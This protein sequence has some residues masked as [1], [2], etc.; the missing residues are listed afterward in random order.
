MKENVTAAL[1]MMLEWF[2]KNGMK[3]NPEKFQMILFKKKNDYCDEFIEIKN[4]TIVN[5][6]CIKLL[7]VHVDSTLNF[8]VH[9]SEICRKA[10]YKLNVL[11]RLSRTLN[12]ESKTMLFHSFIMALFNYCA[13]VWHFCDLQNA[14]CIEKL[15]F[16]ALRY[17]FNDFK[18]S[19]ECLRAKA[20]K[21][22]VYVQRLRHV[23]TEVYKSV[24]GLGP[25]YMTNMFVQKIIK[26]DTRNALCLKI[27]RCNTVKYGLNSFSYQGAKLW[28]SLKN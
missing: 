3:A 12:Q 11:A 1:N 23:L 9:I 14:K 21:S 28:N 17:I 15:Q 13:V 8:N 20:S 10:G 18:S 24:N 2:D 7:G 4:M 5:Q 6:P 26:Y 22:L 19:Y 25:S 16:R 27:P